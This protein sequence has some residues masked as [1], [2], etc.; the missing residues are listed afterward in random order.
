[1]LT[2]EFFNSFNPFPGYQPVTLS[3]YEISATL[4]VDEVDYECDIVA[5]VGKEN[6]DAECNHM[7]DNIEVTKIRYTSKVYPFP[8]YETGEKF[9]NVKDLQQHLDL[10]EKLEELA[11]EH[12]RENRY[13][14]IFDEQEYDDDI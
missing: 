13:D 7:E 5:N 2:R 8:Q 11:T 3:Q 10:I 12:I 1:M 9:A 6:F 4:Q 14:I